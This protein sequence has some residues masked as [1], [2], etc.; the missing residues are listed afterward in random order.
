MKQKEI[1]VIFTI[2][3]GLIIILG[4]IT[5]DNLPHRYCKTNEITSFVILNY[6]NA[7]HVFPKG[8][9]INCDNSY[10]IIKD[11]VADFYVEFTCGAE[12]NQETRYYLYFNQ[13]STDDVIKC[14][15]SKSAICAGTYKEKVCEVR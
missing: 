3:I 6:T 7:F 9:K 1:N 2:I 15:E 4:I 12:Y 8:S 10:V 5:Y 14:L 11:N 13:K